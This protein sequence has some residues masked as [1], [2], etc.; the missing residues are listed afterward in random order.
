MARFETEL[1]IGLRHDS[2]GVYVLNEPLIYTSD[3][4]GKIVV[5][6][7]FNTDFASV[8]RVPVVY[9]AWGDRAH[10]EA[11]IHDYLYRID[12][13]PVAS[14]SD[15][16]RIFLEAMNARSKPWH[17]RY[18]MYAGVV[19]GGYLSYHKRRVLDVL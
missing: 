13:E 8:P 10:R 3:L 4:F 6:A 16:N 14:F 19:I 5:P 7:G 2:D 9:L 11:V 17:I 15:A 1:F 18:P 12:S